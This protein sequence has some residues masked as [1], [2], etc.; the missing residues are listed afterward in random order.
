MAEFVSDTVFKRDVFSET[1]FGYFTDRPDR[2]IA[3]GIVSASPLWSRPLAWILAK[4]EIR[5]LRAVSDIPG[6]PEIVKV[7][8]DGLFR[9]WTEGTPLHLARPDS[10]VWYRNARRLLRKL[11]RRGITHNDL[12]KPQNWLM[13]PDSNAAVID[14]QLASCHGSK[15]RLYRLIGL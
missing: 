8:A 6:A 12:A 4:L 11:R 10:P 1:R 2:R 15:G 9:T 14:F 7:D 5:A 13:L 3:R